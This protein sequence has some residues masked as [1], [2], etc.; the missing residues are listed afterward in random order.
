M[1]NVSASALRDVHRGS[2]DGGAQVL[3]ALGLRAP[4]LPGKA[5]V[6]EGREGGHGREGL[7]KFAGV[8]LDLET[9]R[10]RVRK[11]LQALDSKTRRF[12]VCKDL[13]VLALK[14]QRF[15]ASRSVNPAASGVY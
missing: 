10:F 4:R 8:S 14:T 5:V 11:H 1:A 13:Q 2:G 12:E 3:R 9:N 7:R 15:G 6:D